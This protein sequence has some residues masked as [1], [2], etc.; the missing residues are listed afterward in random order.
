MDLDVPWDARVE[1]DLRG[2]LRPVDPPVAKRNPRLADDHDASLHPHRWHLAR[3]ADTAQI[4]HARVGSDSDPVG[5]VHEPQAS[6]SGRAEWGD[7]VVAASILV[8]RLRAVGRDRV[9]EVHRSCISRFVHAASTVLP[10]WSAAN[11]LDSRLPLY[12]GSGWRRIGQKVDQGGRD[13]WVRVVT[14]S[15]ANPR[16]L[17]FRRNG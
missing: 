8:L 15:R 1:L 2:A 9:P 11:L 16:F 4:P 7:D 3:E 17:R 5:T 6:S 13:S 10:L 12:R 14:A